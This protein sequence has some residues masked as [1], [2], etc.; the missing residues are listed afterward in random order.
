MTERDKRDLER[1]TPSPDLQ[2]LLAE[3]Q[4]LH[5]T[6]IFSKEDMKKLR[7]P[8]V[9]PE[10]GD[11]FNLN[12]P[13]D[14][15]LELDDDQF[16]VDPIFQADAEPTP[17]E[18]AKDKADWVVNDLPAWEEEAESTEQAEVEEEQGQLDADLP[19][20]ELE[21][22]ESS[23]VSNLDLEGQD[24]PNYNPFIYRPKH[25]KPQPTE[26]KASKSLKLPRLDLDAVYEA[27]YSLDHLDDLDAYDQFGAPELTPTKIERLMQNWWQGITQRVNNLKPKE[28]VVAPE[29]E[30]AEEPVVLE[31]NDES[32]QTGS[33]PEPELELTDAK[34]ELAEAEVEPT[35]QVEANLDSVET[36]QGTESPEPSQ[37]DLENQGQAQEEAEEESV[38]LNLLAPVELEE[39]VELA[40]QE[41]KRDDD[42]QWAPVSVLDI[43][44]QEAEPEA[45]SEPVADENLDSDQVTEQEPQ[46]EEAAEPK[47]NLWQRLVRWIQEGEPK[48][49]EELELEATSQEASQTSQPSDESDSDHDEDDSQGSA[50]LTAWEQEVEPEAEHDASELETD[51]DTS[52]SSDFD[53]ELEEE[54]VA[55]HPEPQAA[56]PTERPQTA[57][58]ESP[59]LGQ[60]LAFDLTDT[61]AIT[62]EAIQA[63]SD[64]VSQATQV[65]AEPILTD[66]VLEEYLNEDDVTIEAELNEK[67]T[68][69][70]GA[71]WLTFG[72]IFSRILG[73]IYVIPW[74]AWLGADYLNANTLY[75]A[76]YQPYAL[77]LAIGTA[78]FPS[79]IAK[80][81]AYY[82]SKKQYRFADQLFKASMIVMSLMGLVTATALFFVAPAL[83]AATPTIDHA[84]ATLVIRSLVPPLVIL[85]VMSLLRGY[86]QGYNNM[87]PTAVSQILEQI[88]RVFYMLAATYAVMKL[89][90]GAA[91]TAVI[92][93]TF[94]A[95]IGAAVSLVYLIFVYLRRLPMIKAL[96]E[97][98]QSREEFDLMKTLRIMLIDSVPFIL[99]GSG[100]IIA[101]NIDTYTFGQ[102]MGYTSSLLRSEIAELYGVLSLDVNKLIMI[103]ISLAIGISLSS[104]PAITKRFAEQDKEGTGDLIQHVILLFSFVM[105]P[106]AVGMASIP[107]EV[108]QLFYANGSQSGPGLLVTASY[109]SIV[110]GLYTILSTILQAM[111]F[112]RLSIWHLLI[113]LVVKVVLQ[114]PLVAIFQAQGT[115]LSTGLAFLVSSLLMWRTIH[116][117]VPLRYSEMTPKL[118]KM[119]VGTAL[120]GVSTSIW[121]QVLNGLMGPVGRGMTF[122]KVILVVLVGVFVYMTVMALFGLLPILFGSR[123]KDLQDKMR[124]FS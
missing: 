12:L 11:Y 13:A 32:S 71:T 41:D 64:Q 72:N 104:L 68:I 122:V 36:F 60:Q 22:A 5:E 2:A 121:A 92:H 65:F 77:F 96:I 90:N 30:L 59:S 42:N 33:Q 86:F 78:G 76:G 105:L 35:E 116:K 23:S 57:S 117:S 83:A 56:R 18:P 20:L 21:R 89:F 75:S 14:L 110:L 46:E 6:V 119:L 3:E 15:D 25:P 19:E 99:V 7:R 93:S 100:I 101:Q 107:T 84:A 106:A 114:F 26:A 49:E 94:A 55:G 16:D 81:M 120:M 70:K 73:A 61:Q 74:A 9:Q 115:F 95:F 80:Q 108:Y 63:Y 91:T 62:P 48:E 123:K 10:D 28:E 58:P 29:E 79:A 37:E 69:V 102:I 38:D 124:F 85:P 103:I 8:N 118:V 97:T 40:S 24:D 17:S 54:A 44:E 45:N 47:L 43:D 109:M 39:E 67:Q 112:R 82:H 51:S 31:V 1:G 87:V 111:N 98:D 113:G 52:L 53:L 27:H 88:A 34:V 4:N 66:Q 50:S